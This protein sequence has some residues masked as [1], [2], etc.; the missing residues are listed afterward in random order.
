MLLISP[1]EESASKNDHESNSKGSRLTSCTVNTTESWI[2][3]RERPRIE[4]QGVRTHVLCCWYHRKMNQQTRTTM[5]WILRDLDSHPALSIPPKL[6][7]RTTAPWIL[8]DPNLHPTLS[9]SPKDESAGESDHKSNSKG[10]KHASYVVDT[11]ERWISKQKWLNLS[12]PS[13]KKTWRELPKRPKQQCHEETASRSSGLW[14][15]TRKTTLVTDVKT[16]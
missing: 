2:S 13:S 4:F 8:R 10:S 1:K 3:K 16:G 6:N 9:I 15:N 11:N 12:Y 14:A 5:N 7:Q